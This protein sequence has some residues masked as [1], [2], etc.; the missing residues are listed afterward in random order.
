ML[1]EGGAEAVKLEGGEHL[2][3]QVRAIV[4]RRHPRDGT[5]G[6]PAA[7]GA[8]DGRVSRA[9]HSGGAAEQV[10]ADAKALEDAGAYSIVVEGVPA[11]LG[12]K[13][14]EAVSVPTIG[15]GAGPHRD[16]KG[17]VCYDFLGMYSDVRPKFVKR[18]AELGEAIVAATRSYVDEVREGTFPAEEHSF[19]SAK[20]PPPDRPDR[21][22]PRAG[23]TSEGLRSGE[24]VFMS[25]TLHTAVKDFRAACDAVRARGGASAWCRRWALSMPAT[26][27]WWKRRAA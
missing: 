26:S 13:I 16:G 5:R 17:L 27:R 11:E 9:G 1:K 8:R 14:T 2:A 18:F 3:E 15:I 19:G 21:V 12:K 24:R 23:G 22:T 25:F 7:V 20:F 10:I 6:S 4:L